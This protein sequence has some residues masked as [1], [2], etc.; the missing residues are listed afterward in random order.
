MATPYTAESVRDGL[1]PS[2]AIVIVAAVAPA[3]SSAARS[4]LDRV[5]AGM[6]EVRA[7]C[8]AIPR[9]IANDETTLHL[10]IGASGRVEIARARGNQPIVDACVP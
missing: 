5:T 10:E 2:V 9:E 8:D 1:A 3:T 6:P 4:P 7:K